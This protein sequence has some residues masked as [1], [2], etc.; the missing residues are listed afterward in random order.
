MERVR[1]RKGKRYLP[2]EESHVVRGRNGK[3]KVR[4]KGSAFRVIRVRGGKGH[5]YEG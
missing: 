1:G 4:V 3:V 2:L 5:S